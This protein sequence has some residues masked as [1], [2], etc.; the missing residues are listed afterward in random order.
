MEWFISWL[1][2]QYFLSLDSNSDD[3]ISM[4][5]LYFVFSGNNGESVVNNVR[6]AHTFIY[7]DKDILSAAVET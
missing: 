6:H 5:S 2:R 4:T 3:S 7:L 1:K